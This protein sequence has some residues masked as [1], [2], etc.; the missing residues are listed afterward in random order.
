[1]NRFWGSNIKGSDSFSNQQENKAIV[2]TVINWN[3]RI[4]L[5]SSNIVLQ[6]PRKTDLLS[7]GLLREKIDQ[8]ELKVEHAGNDHSKAYALP[9]EQLRPAPTRVPAIGISVASL[10]TPIYPYSNV[11]DGIQ[12]YEREGR[13]SRTK[14][15]LTLQYALQEHN[16]FAQRRL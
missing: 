13:L 10:L 14:P 9:K 12:A 4:L 11:L 15:S 5:A 3:K 7:I 2:K 8:R 16:Q 6:S 1:M